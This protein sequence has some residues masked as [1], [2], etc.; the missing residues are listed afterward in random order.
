M[1]QNNAH[2]GRKRCA[3]VEVSCRG[4]SVGAVGSCVLEVFVVAAGR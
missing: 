2:I 3:G 4:K 1:S